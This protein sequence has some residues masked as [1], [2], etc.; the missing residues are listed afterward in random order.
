MNR[1]IYAVVCASV[2]FVA[3]QS[4]ADDSMSTSTSTQAMKD[5]M[6][7]Q[8]AKNDGTSKSDMKKAC[9]AKMNSASTS[10]T[11]TAAP[12]DPTTDKNIGNAKTTNK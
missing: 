1:L 12:D 3:A 7:K 6:A 5:C 2:L 8:T 9:E 10:G 11:P 4:F